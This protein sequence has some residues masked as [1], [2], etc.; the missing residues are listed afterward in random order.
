MGE[1]SYSLHIGWE[2]DH[3]YYS[4][5]GTHFF[6]FPLFIGKPLSYWVVPFPIMMDYHSLV[7][8]PRNAFTGRSRGTLH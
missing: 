4:S 1:E 8:I 2:V 7:K 6:S 5:A 3:E